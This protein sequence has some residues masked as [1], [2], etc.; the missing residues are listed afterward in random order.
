MTTPTEQ[1]LTRL[2][3][4]T[5]S[6][7]DVPEH[8]PSEV[9]AAATR[10][11]SAAPRRRWIP[12]SA[13]AA[14]VVLA[15]GFAFQVNNYDGNIDR[16]SAT[17][18][19]AGG[20]AEQSAPQ[21]AQ[22]FS[23]AQVQK[24]APLR[25]ALDSGSGFTGLSGGGTGA[26]SAAGGVVG[27][28]AA[29]AGETND[30]ADGAEARVVTTGS[31]ALQVKEKRVGPTLDAVR[32]AAIAAGGYVAS[33]TSEEASDNP[34][35]ELALRVPAARYETLVG[36]I[37]RLDA[38]VLRAETSA[39]DVTAQFSDLETQLRTLRAARERFLVLL[40]RTRTV[41][42]VL[43]VQQR[44][45]EV[46]GRIDRLEGQRKLLANQSDLSSLTVSITAEGDPVTSQRSGLSQALGDAKN[47]FVSG[48]EGLIRNSGRA[49]L[50]VLCLAVAF[51]VGR[52]LWRVARR[53]LV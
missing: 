38:K 20:F 30:G 1:D 3:T 5:A 14:V 21:P 24:S 17:V 44:V 49:L 39:R 16:Q 33:G 35:G 41:G 48:V 32:K 45:D 53:R 13:A 31:L 7:Y 26:G 40:S 42:E 4:E 36:Q 47:G 50:L 23:G 51:A 12:L 28:T 8:G 11:R 19:G 52:V 43:S 10:R 34:S 9:L 15:A 29:T 22:D 2:L 25:A 18:S 27:G 37:R 46:S 6:S